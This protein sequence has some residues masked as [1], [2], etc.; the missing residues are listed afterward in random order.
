MLPILILNY[1]YNKISHFYC[2]NI[3]SVT[4]FILPDFYFSFS[5]ILILLTFSRY[6]YLYSRYILSKMT[7][8]NM[9]ISNSSITKLNIDSFNSNRCSTEGLSGRSF[10]GVMWHVRRSHVFKVSISWRCITQLTDVPI[11]L[12]TI[13]GCDI[14]LYISFQVKY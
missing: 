1:L 11:S 9:Y 10:G 13:C 6:A 7:H 2:I 3:L 12:S 14:S 5:I 8:N 4:M